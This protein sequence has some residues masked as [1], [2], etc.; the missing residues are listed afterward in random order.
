MRTVDSIRRAQLLLILAFVAA[1]L[2][3]YAGL[4]ELV[5]FVLLA[6]AIVALFGGLG[7]NSENGK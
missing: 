7:G 3:I 5:A 2:R 4:D 1:L 6:L